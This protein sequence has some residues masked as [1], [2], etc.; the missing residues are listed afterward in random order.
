M[1]GRHGTWH[2]HTSTHLNP[3]F[4]RRCYSLCD[5]DHCKREDIWPRHGAFLR[6]IKFP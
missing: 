2:I 3:P 6:P 5:L 4:E 1:L